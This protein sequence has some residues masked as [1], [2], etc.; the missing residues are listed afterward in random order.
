[1]KITQGCYS[2]IPD[3]TQAQ[4]ESHLQLGLVNKWAVSLEMTSDPHP[5]NTYW[6]MHREPRFYSLR[7]YVSAKEA[8]KEAQNLSLHS[9][10][11][12]VSEQSP[13]T[14]PHCTD[15]SGALADISNCTSANP[16]KYIKLIFFDSTRGI[17]SCAMSFLIRRPSTEK[18]LTMIR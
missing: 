12:E 11:E 17:E 7:G 16:N 2:Y 15:I 13:P 8:A 1:M 6:E 14:A 4:I 18:T 3:V 10:D 5:R 9:K